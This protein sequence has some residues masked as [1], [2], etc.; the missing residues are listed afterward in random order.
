MNIDK[1]IE[2][3]LESITTNDKSINDAIHYFIES[4]PGY[5]N[6]L[7]SSLTIKKY[8]RCLIDD[9]KYSFKV[10][11]NSS[12][13]ERLSQIS[14][15][16]L[17][18]YKDFL[19]NFLEVHTVRSYITAVKQ[20]LSCC[21][22][23]EWIGKDLLK[24]YHLPKIVKPHEI[25][26][27]P[28]EVQNEILGN[29]WGTNPFMVTRN[30]LI[31]CFFIRH[32]LRPLEFPRIKESHIHP[33]KDLCY[34]DIY[35][36]RLQHRQVMLDEVSLKALREYMVQRAAFKYGKKIKNDH[37]FLCMIPRN[38]SYVISKSGVQAVVR[39]IK[40]EL[41]LRGCLWNLDTLNPQGCRR[42]AV[43]REYEKAEYLPVQHPE[44]TLS[45]QFGHSFAIAQQHYWK[46]SMK[47]AYLMIKGGEQVEKNLSSEI[48]PPEGSNKSTDI[49]PDAS[50]FKDFGMDI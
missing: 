48:L 23:L 37:L 10:Y 42:S 7:H 29:E 12:S 8:K 44:F 28:A 13:V 33:Y 20:F 11:L 38:G 15:Q 21:Q 16:Q 41:Q 27:I 2:K 6:S 39:R 32:G 14:K 50:F 34:L 24:N 30:H 3:L 5:K 22:R 36:K 19:L 47:N 31:N 45:G 26:T 35:G 17:E 40:Q 46:K 43:S 9:P 18:E 25:K 49:Y 1:D 4:L